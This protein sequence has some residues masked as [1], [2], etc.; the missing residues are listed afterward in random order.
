MPI[1]LLHKPSVIPTGYWSDDNAAFWSVDSDPFWRAIFKSLV[2]TFDV[3]PP[4]QFIPARLLIEATVQ[5]SA[6]SLEYSV[7]GSSVP[8]WT[9]DATPFWTNDGDPFWTVAVTSGYLPWPG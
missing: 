3:T 7:L 5:A 1:L 2:Y 6:W 9:G 8:F 4:P